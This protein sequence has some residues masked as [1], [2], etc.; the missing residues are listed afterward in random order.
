MRRLTGGLFFIWAVTFLF[1]LPATFDFFFWRRQIILLTG[2]LSF[3]YMSVAMLLAIRPAW[4]EKRLNGLD[5]MYRLH[6]YLGIGSLVA[7]SAHWLAFKAGKWLTQAGV[8]QRPFRPEAPGINWHAI[9]NDIGE[10]AFYAFIVFALVS[11]LKVVS[12][13]RFV[14]LHKL[15]GVIFIAGAV[16]GAM[17]LKY[18]MNTMLYDIAIIAMALVGCYCALLSLTSQ[19][20]SNKKVNGTVTHVERYA[21]NAVHFQI[22]VNQPMKYQPGQFAY[23]NFHDGESPHPFTVVNYDKQQKIIEI[24]VKALGDYT[25]KLVNHLQ[26]GQQVEVEGGYGKFLLSD[27]KKQVW[28]GAGIG[29]TPFIAWLESMA[30]GSNAQTSAEKIIFFYCARNRQEA[31]FIER[32]QRLTRRIS[33]VELRVL[34]ADDGELLTPEEIIHLMDNCTDYSVS[35]CG[36]ELFA[37]HLKKGLSASG[38]CQSQFHHEIFSM[39]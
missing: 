26:T 14:I 20:G 38:W 39:R 23:L 28:V 17:S 37:E 22:T 7:L 18:L 34:L 11:L 2:I 4:L 24:A 13:K 15:A 3:G 29:V 5:K 27:K 8:V 16:H 12:Y 33:H 31:F 32:L 21:D 19:I 35:F 30:S 1:S 10:W 25:A 36:P 6:K 9:A